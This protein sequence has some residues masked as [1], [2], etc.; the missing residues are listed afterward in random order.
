M[1]LVSPAAHGAMSDHALQPPLIQTGVDANVMIN[2][3]IETPMQ[4]AAYNDW[5]DGGACGGRPGP[6][7]GKPIGNCYFADRSY[8]GYFDPA[9]C[10]VYDTS[11][12]RFEPAAADSAHG[13]HGRWS[14]NMLNW[15]TMTAIDEFRWALT[16]GHRSTDT[17]AETVLE[18]AVLDSDRSNGHAWFPV[19]KLGSSVNVDPDT[20]MPAQIGGT[21]VPDPVYLVSYGRQFKVCS[22][23]DCSPAGTVIASDIYARVKVCDEDAGLEDSC[24]PYGTHHKPEG[25]I[26]GYSNNLRFA[27]MSYLFDDSHDRH[28]G[29]LRANMK[30]VGPFRPTSVGGIEVNPRA[31]WSAQSGV[32][33]ANPNGA[34]ASASGVSNSGVINYIDQFGANGYKAYDP[35]G[36]I[37]YECINY[38]KDRGPTAEYSANLTDAMKDGFPVITAWEDP[39]THRCQRNYIVGINDANPWEDKRLPGTAIADRSYGGYSMR[40]QS[41]DW[42]EP[43]NA[44]SAIDVTR[45]TNVV[46]DLQG[47]SGTSQCVGCVPGNCNMSADNK[48]ISELG[49][50][51]GSCPYAPKENSYYIAGLAYYAN[52]QDLRSDHTGRQTVTTFLIDTQEYSTDPLVG[53]MNML[54]LAGKFGGFE[55][56]NRQ[57]TNNDGNPYEPDQPAEWDADGDG[58]PDNYVL[59][60]NPERLVTGLSRAFSGIE[61]RLSAGSAAAVIANEAAGEGHV[62]QAVYQPKLTNTN[63][64]QQVQWV[65]LVHAIFIDA[66]GELREDTNGNA[67]LDDCDTDRIIAVEYDDP[68]AR[69]VVR[70]YACNGDLIDFRELDNFGTVWDARDQLAALDND[71]VRTQRAYGTAVSANNTRHILTWVDDNADGAVNEDEVIA[72][73]QSS[74]DA[75][76]FRY[77]DVDTL[78]EARDIVNFVRGHDGISGF[79][80][81]RIDYDNDGTDEVLRL[82][83]VVHSSP[84]IVGPPRAGY[85]TR[86]DDDSYA[87]FRAKYQNRRQM[88]YVGAND[89]MLHAFNSGFWNPVQNRFELQDGS[90]ATTHPLGAEVW[91]YVPMN[92]LPH[93]QWLKELDY[94]HVYYVDGVPQAFDVNI[95]A[96]DETHV[97]GWGTLLVVPMRLGGNPVGVDANN[98][99]TDD[100]T[101][102]SAYILLDVTDPEQ[103]PVL[104]AEVTHP[105]LG[106]TTSRPAL[107]RRRVPSDGAGWQNPAVN[108][109]YLA[110]GSGPNDLQSATSDQTAKLFLYDLSSLSFVPGLA[111]LDLRLANSFV[112]D[113]ASQ[114]WDAR[115]ADYVDDAVYFG[116]AGGTAAVQTGTLQRLRV[117]DFTVHELAD[118]GRPY[119]S[120]PYAFDYPPAGEKWVYTGSGRLY[121]TADA[122]TTQPQGMYGIK[123]PVNDS[124]ELTWTAVALGHLQDVTGVQVFEGGFLTDPSGVLPETPD[125][126]SFQGLQDYIRENRGGWYTRFQAD[127]SSPSERSLDAVVRSQSSLLYTSYLPSADEC[128]PEGTSAL[129]AVHFA[130]GTANP[131][132][133]LGVNT[134]VLYPHETVQD[135]LYQVRD[136]VSLGKG[137]KTG[138]TIIHTRA[139]PKALAQGSP[140]DLAALEVGMAP[141]AAGRQTWREIPLE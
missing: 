107:V 137:T 118:P 102:R 18:R 117:A 38:Y 17:A 68:L 37:F 69:T 127:G 14:G 106:F 97:N 51:F 60:T 116:T 123:E 141:V 91:A 27:V 67:T 44:D 105:A 100:F 121:V 140:G 5:D 114:N 65:G 90:G 25:L 28:G 15:A 1:S 8:I 42:G 56:I 59:A 63:R 33:V 92:L 70:R 7:S 76:N 134:L 50:A 81:R 133:P 135:P 136:Y 113:L 80:S 9:K 10:Y 84:A 120:A 48:T 87:E 131:A 108:D 82:G 57:D 26:Q 34:D 41:N 96:R 45:L 119:L 55:E 128:E 101:G 98:D 61:R 94:P 110:I 73:D 103:P 72:F 77:L 30:Y 19:K 126:D 11:D 139:G 138:L 20:V 78:A 104:L 52:T 39:I 46:G 32:F 58:E 31:E 24:R 83:D 54:W 47:I 74:I 16:G 132:T 79:R 23:A 86:H 36:E 112:G 35:I 21:S 43:D 125:I 88:V 13:C 95:F 124:G 66:Q 109:W 93:L 62:I 99:G 85:D 122:R 115:T 29:V 6:E 4:G 40:S 111:P 53:Q 49:R 129:S 130:T 71:R 12:Q 75:D 89:G 64:G 22:V 3:S 2:L